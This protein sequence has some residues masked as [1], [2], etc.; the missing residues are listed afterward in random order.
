MLALQL[1]DIKRI[2]NYITLIKIKKM[3]NF[4]FVFF[5]SI[6]WGNCFAQSY[7]E[8][9]YFIDNSGKKVECLIKNMDWKNNPTKFEYK[10]S[11]DS[12]LNDIGGKQIREIEIY[13][14]LKYYKSIVN[15]D[16]SS[17]KINSL[18]SVKDPVFNK[19][20]LLLKVLVEGEASLFE[21]VDGNLTRFFFKINNKDIEQLVYKKYKI[22]FSTIAENEYFKKQL[23]DVLK[24]DG[25][26]IKGV[27]DVTYKKAELTDLFVKYNECSSSEFVNFDKRENKELFNLILR[28]GVNYAS[29]SA[30]SDSRAF[31]KCRFWRSSW[32]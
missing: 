9:G 15:I 17:D 24:C 6:I 5:A 30:S 4:L 7:F 19:E 29:F 21:Y 11:E 13:D 22:D 14:K 3:R 27:Q 31:K 16:R 28:P 10:L 12:E 2:Y 25:V 8:K 23:W 20:E 18:T 1:M 32:V 26:L